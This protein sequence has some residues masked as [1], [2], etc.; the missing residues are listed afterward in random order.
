MGKSG[1]CLYVFGIGDIVDRMTF[2]FGVLYIKQDVQGLSISPII[3]QSGNRIF[4]S[5]ATAIATKMF[6]KLKTHQSVLCSE[7]AEFAQKR[8]L[9]FANDILW[10]SNILR[11]YEVLPSND[12]QALENCASD[13]EPE[14]VNV[15]DFIRNRLDVDFMQNRYGEKVVAFFRKIRLCH[16]HSNPFEW[17]YAN[18][19]RYLNSAPL[20]RVLLSKRHH[21]YQANTPFLLLEKG[22]CPADKNDRQI[23][24]IFNACQCTEQADWDEWFVETM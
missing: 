16:K 15:V 7:I 17:W 10:H 6:K 9:Q 11:S 21:L 20:D 18:E 24:L 23:N 1:D 12:S 5:N 13:R 2:W 14:T 22:G 8:D 3:V 19:K 4:G